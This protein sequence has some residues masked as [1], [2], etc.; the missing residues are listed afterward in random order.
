MKTNNKVAHQAPDSLD[1][2]IFYNRN[3]SYGAFELRK[4]YKRRLFIGLLISFFAFGSAIS[5]PLIKAYLIKYQPP[6]VIADVDPRIMDSLRIEQPPT[7]PPPPPVN[8]ETINKIKYSDPIVADTI[9]D[10]KDIGMMDNAI[11]DDPAALTL[12]TPIDDPAPI[13]EEEKKY[14][15]VEEQ[16]TYDGGTVEK[17]RLWVAKN[18]SYPPDADKIGI[19]GRV[20]VIF[21]VNRFGKISDI[22]IHRGV[23]PTLDE[24]VI[25]TI[26]NSPDKWKPA[27]QNGNPVK[28]M[29]MITIFFQQVN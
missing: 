14:W 28:Q 20:M 7:P 5:V 21:G 22:S 4:K 2:V 10:L 13:I 11:N 18:T 29:F 1:E 16:A 3:M 6:I 26:A 17:F 9:T 23:H 12:T 19:T 24:A 15:N 25:K 27:K 8:S